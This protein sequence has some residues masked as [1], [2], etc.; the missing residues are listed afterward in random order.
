VGATATETPTECVMNFV[1][2]SP[3]DFFYQ[4]VLYLY[5]HGVISGYNTNPPCGS[6]V[7]CFNPGGTTTRGQLSKIAVL[8]FNLPIN[9]AGGPHFSDVSTDNPF[10]SYIETLYN[11]GVIT[12]Y[13]DGTFRPNSFVTRG[14]ITKIIVLTAAHV[15]PADWQLVNPANSTFEDVPFGSTFYTYVETAVSHGVISGYPCGAPPA[16]VCV[17]PDNKPYFLPNNNATRAQISKVAYL[18]ITYMPPAAT[19]TSLPATATS[20]R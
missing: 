20:T 9:T 7:P 8:G 4:Y 14:Q 13:D 1:D 12:G 5:C 18:S 6:G 11:A 15:D 16:G 17:P 10:Y 19:P 2:V 3:S